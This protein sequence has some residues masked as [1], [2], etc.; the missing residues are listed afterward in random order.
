MRHKGS[1]RFHLVFAPPSVTPA[2]MSKDQKQKSGAAK[3][4][5]KLK[6]ADKQARLAEALRANLRRRKE[7]T[8]ERKAENID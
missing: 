1:R 6:S 5:E 3:Q 8:R 4:G 2:A 7:Q